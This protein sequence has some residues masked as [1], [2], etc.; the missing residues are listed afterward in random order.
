MAALFY[1]QQALG[2]FGYSRSL[3]KKKRSSTCSSCGQRGALAQ[4]RVV[5]GR[6]LPH[7]AAPEINF[8]NFT[9]SRLWSAARMMDL[10]PPCL[11]LTGLRPRHAPPALSW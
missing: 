8:T 6:D 10:V 3:A 11:L 7:P 4:G 9:S 2:C 5:A 1:Y